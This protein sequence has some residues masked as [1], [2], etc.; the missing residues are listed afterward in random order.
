MDGLLLGICLLF[1]LVFVT[2]L[3]LGSEDSNLK[4][5]FFEKSFRKQQASSSVAVEKMRSICTVATLSQPTELS[6]KIV[7]LG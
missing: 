7:S 2:I 3:Q 4:E 1:V 6:E 5:L